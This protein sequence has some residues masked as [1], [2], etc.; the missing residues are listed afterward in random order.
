VR[1]RY[2]LLNRCRKFHCRN[3]KRADFALIAEGFA[4]LAMICVMLKRLTEPKLTCA[5]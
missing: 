2:D 3:I 4:K 1:E 5:M